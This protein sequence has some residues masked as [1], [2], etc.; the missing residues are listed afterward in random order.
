MVDDRYGVQYSCPDMSSNR[1]CLARRAMTSAP[2]DRAS[3]AISHARVCVDRPLERGQPIEVL[4]LTHSTLQCIFWCMTTSPVDPYT[5]HIKTGNGRASHRP[6]IC[7]GL[8]MNIS[9]DEANRAARHVLI[10]LVK[11]TLNVAVAWGVLQAVV[12]TL[13]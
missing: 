7:G 1:V 9:P 13:Y 10:G 8:T 5:R 12:N 4:N 6:A 2:T 11:F 3:P